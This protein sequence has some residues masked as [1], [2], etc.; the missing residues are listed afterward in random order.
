MTDDSNH[1]TLGEALKRQFKIHDRL[2]AEMDEALQAE[3]ERNKTQAERDLEELLALAQGVWLYTETYTLPGSNEQRRSF[4][5]G[6]TEYVIH[7]SDSGIGG[8]IARLCEYL[9][10]NQ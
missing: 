6:D 7:A 1:V 2:L 10:A 3:A 4:R 8:A 5:Y 9:E